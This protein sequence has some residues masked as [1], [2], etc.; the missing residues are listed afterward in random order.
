MLAVLATLVVAMTLA[1]RSAQ[2]CSEPQRAAAAAELLETVRAAKT[3]PLRRPCL[4]PPR[5]AA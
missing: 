4:Q 2:N 3:P 1:L 5:M